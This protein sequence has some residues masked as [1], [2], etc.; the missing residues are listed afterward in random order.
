MSISRRDFMKAFGVSLASLLLA[1]CKR[2]EL[3]G[4]LSTPTEP[5]QTPMQTCYEPTMPPVATSTPMA[6]NARERLRAYWLD[7]DTLA[8]KTAE[9]SSG[10]GS[11]SYSYF[12]QLTADHRAALDEMVA[13]GSLTQE[14]ADLV[15]E[16]F[17]AAAY[18]VWRSSV[19]ITCYITAGPV[20]AQ[21]SASVLIR[22]SETLEELATQGNIDPET[23]ARARTALEHDLAF[24]AL[25]EADLQNLY[26]Q[27]AKSGQPYPPFENVEV[28][29]TPDAKVAA[30]F[31]IDLLTGK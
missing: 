1:R 26:D 7:F 18:H 6:L 24:Y 29:M 16:A 14:V 23:L 20:Y 25:S 15:L 12:R 3:P 8:R 17:D 11:A 9:E 13:A 2:L 4:V 28:G 5:F 21:E 27:F 30:Q 22:Q 10:D 19:P 31:L